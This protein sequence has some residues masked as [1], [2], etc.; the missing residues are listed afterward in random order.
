MFTSHHQSDSFLSALA[1]ERPDLHKQLSL[2][3]MVRENCPTMAFE[4]FKIYFDALVDRL[5]DGIHY[6]TGTKKSH[7]AAPQTLLSYLLSFASDIPK[8]LKKTD[9]ASN[10]RLL[11]LESAY[12]ILDET[13]S[14]KFLTAVKQTVSEFAEKK[15]GPIHVIDA[16]CGAIPI[17]AI[18]AAIT[19]P[20]VKVI[21]LEFNRASCEMAQQIIESI[22][23]KNQIQVIEADATKYIPKVRPALVISETMQAGFKEEP[24]TKILKH[25]AQYLA[26]DGKM[27]PSAA[28]IYAGIFQKAHQDRSPGQ[29]YSGGMLIPTYFPS[30]ED[31]SKFD[32]NNTPE[33]FSLNFEL[34]VNPKDPGIVVVA[35]EIYLGR[36]KLKLNESLIT[37]PTPVI[38]IRDPQRVEPVRISPESPKNKV[39][40]MYPP[41]AAEPLG[42]VLCL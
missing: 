30:W 40:I 22:G 42:G 1:S 18:Q 26:D 32:F 27:I 38:N 28:K 8:V 16:G 6:E 19:N 5:T 13:R 15:S 37:M 24:I 34:D 35:A 39:I 33:Y 36:E 31:H 2:A 4:E 11:L 14:K 17:L 20:R 29:I 21:A 12:C 9:S 23:L 25:L 7:N 3:Q 41:G 10:G